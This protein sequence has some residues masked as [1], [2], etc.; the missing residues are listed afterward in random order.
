M[1]QKVTKHDMER[2]GYENDKMHRH[3]MGPFAQD[4]YFLNMSFFEKRGS[5]YLPRY[6]SKCSQTVCGSQSPYCST[7]EPNKVKISLKRDEK[8]DDQ[9]VKTNHQI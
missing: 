5:L 1:N 2:G 4:G 8:D 6:K 3:F 9:Q 7:L